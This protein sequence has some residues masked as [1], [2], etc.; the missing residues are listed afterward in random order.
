M[1]K[2][3]MIALLLTVC[4]STAF[5][6]KNEGAV[7]VSPNGVNVNANG[8]TTV[9]LTFGGLNN[10]R[11]AEGMWCGEL[12]PATPDARF[13]CNPATIYGS[14]PDRYDFSVSSGRQAMT[15]VM[16]IPPSVA[17]RAYQDA[18]EGAKS[19]FFYVRHFV[20][21]KGG[22][23]EY[24]FV[25]CRMAGGGASVPLALTNVKL[26]FGDDLPLTVI[27]PGETLPPIKAEIA[28]NGAGRLIGRW[29]VMMPGDEA[30]SERDLLTEATLPVE[31]RGWQRRYTQLSRFNVFLAPTGKHILPG[32]DA[33]RL[34]TFVEGQYL[35][36]LRVEVSD[37]PD[38]GSNLAAVKA[39]SGFI[40]SGAVAGFALPVLR[41][42]VG[43]K[44]SGATAAAASVPT[45]SL[46]AN[47]AAIAN[48]QALEFRW[49]E[50]PQ[51]A[52]YR[53]ELED[54][55]EQQLLSA[56]LRRG[57]TIY[58][59]PSWFKEKAGDGILRWR[60]VAFDQSGAVIGESQW[61]VLKLIS[62]QQGVSK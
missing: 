29:E 54:N 42:F 17:R 25:T 61:R 37:D 48:D 35:V 24:V 14:L 47:E 34:P 22:P 59:A 27:E 2:L 26:A 32:P 7:K 55:K 5:A 28:Y 40:Q 9:F 15:D 31:E 21:L 56:M 3:L 45:L 6:Q 16:S 1:N 38:S 50:S 4:D 43:S 57:V 58:R 18:A 60:V 46:P 30:P 11:P 10:Y 23:D 53:L 62:K 8:A 12:I 20:N 51:A 13:K 44:V 36:L 39:G 19:S 41:Y 52:A 49:N 33:S